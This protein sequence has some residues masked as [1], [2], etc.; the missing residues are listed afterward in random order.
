MTGQ[1]WEY[2]AVFL[3]TTLLC[4]MLTPLAMKYALSANVLDHPGDHKSHQEAVPYLGGLAIVGTFTAAVLVM[5]FLHHSYSGRSELLAVL[6]IA[7]LLSLVGLIDD[8]RQVPATWRLVA[9]IAAAVLVWS[10]GSGTDVTTIEVI[11]LGL[12]ILWFV[13]ITNAFNLLDNMDGLSAGLAAVSSLTIFAIAA[14]NGQYLVAALAVA[15]TG[16]AA[17]FLRH[18]FYPA[19]I[20]MG[21]GGA[22]FIGF[23]VAYIGIKLR[24]EGGRLLGAMVPILA[25]SAAVFD[26]SLVTIAR[27]AAKRSPF[28]GGQDH[29]SHRLVRLG[30]RVPV[31]VGTIYLAAV[32]VGVLAYVISNS[33]PTSAWVL[34]GLIVV[35]LVITGGFL[36][37]VP[38]YPGNSQGGSSTTGDS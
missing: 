8:L 25:C 26:T 16:C 20:Y 21:D 1:W 29:V 17:G 3:V 9:E 34:V 2:L 19:R 38:V 13:G 24:F 23:L 27:L 31:A 22:L 32:G 35:T 36:L 30:L 37:T 4:G 10:L 28:Q 7:I 14:D 33:E 11:D 15:L 6:A 5:A 18:N 12:T